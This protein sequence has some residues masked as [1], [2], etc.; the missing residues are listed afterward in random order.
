M[1]RAS[2]WAVALLLAACSPQVYPLHLEIRQPSSSGLD[3]NRKTMSI[4]YMDGFND[5]DS[6]LDRTAASAMARYLEEDYFG[7]DEVVGIYHIPSVDS[8]SVELMRSLVMDTDKDVV[9]LLS[10]HW[11]NPTPEDTQ[12][13]STWLRVYDSLGEDRVLSYSGS[14][15]VPS[16]EEVGKRVSSRFLSNW[17]KESF[18]FYYFEGT[19]E[20]EW[21]QAI[22]YASEGKFAKA[23]DVWM[24]MV[25][26]GGAVKR[27]CAAYNIAQ[28]FYLMEDYSLSSQWLDLAEKTENV[29]LAAGL[30][31][32]LDSHLEKT[33]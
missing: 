21:V 10:S 13:V 32:R 25:K 27:A 28:A 18:S 12:P 2:I 7:G 15:V 9:F 20:D 19:Q 14:A 16:A 1:K 6:L 30:R 5:R 24:P 33:Q 22:E 4:V 8:V 3:L 11:D 29:F 23:V 26:R 31:K 17:K